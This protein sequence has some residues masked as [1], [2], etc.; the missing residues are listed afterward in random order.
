MSSIKLTLTAWI[1][2]SLSHTLSIS[3]SQSLVVQEEHGWNFFFYGKLW[4]LYSTYAYGVCNCMYAY[5][6]ASIYGD[7]GVWELGEK[8]ELVCLLFLFFIISFPSCYIILVLLPCIIPH[9]QLSCLSTLPPHL[10]LL[11]APNFILWFAYSPSFVLW[12]YLLSL[13]QSPFVLF[14]LSFLLLCPLSLLPPFISF[15]FASTLF[16]PLTPFLALFF[17][18]PV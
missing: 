8:E 1:R 17:S 9:C 5:I 7:S 15:P 6:C 10:S 11:N 2:I 18:C 13:S 14:P 12:P 4:E 3:L 16:F